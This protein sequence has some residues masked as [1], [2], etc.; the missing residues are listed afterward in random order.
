ML[1]LVTYR[2]SELDR[3][4]PLR[5]ALGELGSSG[6]IR[7]LRLAPLS[8]EG[9]RALSA[10]Y[11]ADAEE[12]Y[13]RTGGN[14]FFVAEAIATD[15]DVPATVR[16]AVLARAARLSPTAWALLEAVAVS[17]PQAELS[18]LET[19]AP[20]ALASVD[21]CI[22]AGMLTSEG[23][24]L[25]FRHELAR[26]SV[27]EA[28]APDRVLALNRAI[29]RSL[30]TTGPVAVDA[31]RLSHHADAAGEPEAV[32]RYATAAAVRAAAV[33]AHHE[34]AAQYARALRF[35]SASPPDTYAAALRA[36]LPR[37]LSH[38]PGRGCAGRHPGGDSDVPRA[39]RPAS[40]GQ[41]SPVARP[42]PPQHGQP[43]GGRTSGRGGSVAVGG[44]PSGARARDG[45][46]RARGDRA[47]H[48]GCRADRLL[49]DAGDGASR[50]ASTTARRISPR[51]AP[52]GPPARS[53]ARMRE[54][55]ARAAARHG[56]RAGPGE[57]RRARVRAP[58][59]GRLPRAVAEPDDSLRRARARVLRAAGSG[60]LGPVPPCDAELGRAPAR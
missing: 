19:I 56:H 10:P 20:E 49:G 52:S 1:V 24:A 41:R 26:L 5:R 17:P 35:A 53:A 42:R 38:D 12:L 40:G 47:S 15:Q 39:R 8:L 45:V 59:D 6:S 9:V 33:G 3:F 25:R 50:S 22:G 7:R 28:V 58:R 13:R 60:R 16:D 18:L 36:P 43:T 48:R 4:H 31:A 21:E 46:R 34:A 57:S 2:D 37:V 11:R 54:A 23:Q 51:S 14:P 44:A 27:E 32:L 30:E 29:L 55:H